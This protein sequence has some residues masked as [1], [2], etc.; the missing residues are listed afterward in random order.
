MTPAVPVPLPVN[1]VSYD[2]E[3]SLNCVS[4]VAEVAK[5]ASVEVM[6]IRVRNIASRIKITVAPVKGLRPS[7]DKAFQASPSASN[8]RSD[9]VSIHR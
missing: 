8:H 1:V 2:V 9:V 6:K 3:P 5:G 4:V 7:A